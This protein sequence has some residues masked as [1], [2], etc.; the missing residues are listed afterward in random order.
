MTVGLLMEVI[1]AQKYSY[2]SEIQ[3]EISFKDISITSLL[4]GLKVL[5]VP[6]YC[7]DE[8]YLDNNKFNSCLLHIEALER[9]I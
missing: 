7:S 4:V 2:P 5:K 6:L 1:N 8:K 9:L 3:C